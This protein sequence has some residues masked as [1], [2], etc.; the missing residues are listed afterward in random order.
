MKRL[1][2]LYS[3]ICLE[4]IFSSCSKIY[5]EPLHFPIYPDANE[6]VTYSLTYLSSSPLVRID[7]FRRTMAIITNSEEEKGETS[8]DLIRTWTS[9]ENPYGGKVS[10]TVPG[11]ARADELI[12]YTFE[13]SNRS[14]KNTSHSVVHATRLFSDREKAIPVFCQGDVDQVFDLVFIPDSAIWMTSL[15][16][17]Y[18]SV[19]NIIKNTIHREPTLKYLSKQFNFYV[20]PEPGKAY[21]ANFPKSH[22]LPTGSASFLCFAEG[23]GILHND[24]SISDYFQQISIPDDT[25][26]CNLFSSEWNRPQ[27]VLH[28]MAHAMFGLEDEYS[29]GSNSEADPYPNNWKERVD[30]E[31]VAGNYFKSITAVREININPPKFFKL[32]GEWCPMNSGHDPNFVFDIPC[33]K[34][35]CHIILDNIT[36]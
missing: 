4:V 36:N 33:H 17:F 6:A 1:L 5:T 29:G 23:L 25:L 16:A 9:F 10:F 21:D 18:D 15:E 19:H 20:F 13:V 26:T 34:R 12:E 7:L 35:S 31:N 24:T 22:K 8:N 14:G 27:T 2:Y 28:E 3:I 11:T 32:C 30:A